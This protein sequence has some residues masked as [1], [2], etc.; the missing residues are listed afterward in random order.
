MR[1]LRYSFDEGSASLWRGRQSALVST[2]II[3][4]ALLVLGGFL[5]AVVNLQ[6]LTAEWSRTAG[7]SIHSSSPIGRRNTFSHACIRATSASI[8]PR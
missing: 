6:Q 4:V 2:A 3:S 1:A 7:M 5:I 8:G